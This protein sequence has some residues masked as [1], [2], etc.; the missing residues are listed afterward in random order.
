[1][2]H[3]RQG[4]L[5]RGELMARVDAEDSQERVVYGPFPCDS[6]GDLFLSINATEINVAK[7]YCRDCP[8][9]ILCQKNAEVTGSSGIWGGE[10]YIDGKKS[11]Q[12]FSGSKAVRTM[13][14]DE[15]FNDDP[16]SIEYDLDSE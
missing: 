7:S 9:R 8:H 14:D 2:T 4:H 3:N 10:Y 13:S 12:P 16:F 11:E 15:A 6:I 5:A 1:M